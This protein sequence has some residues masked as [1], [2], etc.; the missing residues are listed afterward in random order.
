MILRLLS[1]ALLCLALPACDSGGDD[2][3]DDGAAEGHEHTAPE[4]D[5]ATVT[6]PSFSEMSAWSKCTNCHSSTLTEAAR[7]A[8]PVGV[9]FD[10]FASAR[11]SAEHAMEEVYTDRMPLPGHPALTDAER[12]QIYNWASCGTPE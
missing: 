12:D 1:L 7:N 10:T 6:A 4:V 3:D 2:D 5:C 8:A 9:D 11:S